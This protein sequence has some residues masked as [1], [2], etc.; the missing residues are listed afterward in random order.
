MVTVRCGTINADAVDDAIL[1][2]SAV[3]ID[4]GDLTLASGDDAIHGGSIV[5]TES[6]Q[7]IESEVITINDGFIDL[8]ATDD[9][10]RR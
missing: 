4:G 1:S 2:N 6:F 8:T 9:G 5:I 7:G 3:T 10:L